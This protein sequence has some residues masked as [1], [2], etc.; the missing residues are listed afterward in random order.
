MAP[1]RTIML[2]LAL[3]G[4]FPATAD[5]QSGLLQRATELPPIELSSGKPLAQ[6]PYE[7]E[8]GKY[9]RLTI[10][11]DGSQELALAG[12]EFFRNVWINEVVINDI[13]VRPLGLDSLEFDAEG[14]ATISFVPIRP[15]RFELRIPGTT[16]ASQRAEFL[17][18]G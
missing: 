12:P 1:I 10:R 3:A 17:V 9:Y 7:I 18:K 5:A 4:L 2:V 11:S 16:G 8:A 14:E 15:G 13:E 6:A